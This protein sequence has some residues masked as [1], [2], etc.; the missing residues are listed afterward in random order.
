MPPKKRAKHQ[1]QPS[2]QQTFNIERVLCD[3]SIKDNRFVDKMWESDRGFL[4][5]T[6]GVYSFQDRRLLTFE[7]AREEGVCI[8]FDT[9]RV[10]TADVANKDREDLI[11]GFIEGALPEEERRKS[12]LNFLSMAVACHIEGKRWFGRT[13]AKNWF[14]NILCKLLMDAFIDKRV[15]GVHV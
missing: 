14:R 2:S 15:D 13:G 7:E 6:N 4:A 1:L 8:E 12:F 9:K 3:Q 11:L 10:Y 5:Y